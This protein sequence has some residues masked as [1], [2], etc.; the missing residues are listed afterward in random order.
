MKDLKVWRLVF[1]NC[2]SSCPRK[3]Q[4]CGSKIVPKCLWPHHDKEFYWCCFYTKASYRLDSNHF[5]CNPASY[6]EEKSKNKINLT[7][8]G[9][10][11]GWLYGRPAGDDHGAEA[12]HRVSWPGG[13][14]GTRQ[15]ELLGS[16]VAQTPPTYPHL[17]LLW[18]HPSPPR[19]GGHSQRPDR[20]VLT[21]KGHLLFYSTFRLK[22]ETVNCT[23]DLLE[24]GSRYVVCVIIF[25]KCN[26]LLSFNLYF[27]IHLKCILNIKPIIY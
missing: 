19:G 26:N 10:P 8:S 9:L 18:L 11:S 6:L 15:H 27:K 24:F 16:K 25:I 12:V 23:K 5:C 22:T 13:R 21:G 2:S 7:S 4:F 3:K 14:R 20:S 1:G 17:R